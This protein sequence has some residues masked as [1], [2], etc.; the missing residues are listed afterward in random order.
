MLQ[1]K[2]LMSWL[3]RSA[4]CYEQH[5]TR[6]YKQRQLWNAQVRHF[7][8]LAFSGPA[9]SVAPLHVD[10][11]SQRSIQTSETKYEWGVC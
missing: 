11:G 10:V 5:K 2:M 7:P 4:E 1:Q 3:L 8:G 6:R 9:F